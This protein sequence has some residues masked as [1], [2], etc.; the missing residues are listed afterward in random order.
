M[1]ATAAHAATKLPRPPPVPEPLK[2]RIVEATF[3]IGVA[4]VLIVGLVSDPTDLPHEAPVLLAWLLTIVV[5]DLM[6]VPLWGN[7]V[8]SLSL[9]VLLA[10]GMTFSPLIA[11]G[12]AFVGSNDPR[13]FR[14]EVS[15]LHG[16][17]NRSQI[18]ASTLVASIVFHTTGGS[19][20]VWPHVLG[21][22][23][24]AVGADMVVN[25]SLVVL[26]FVLSLSC[27]SFETSMVPSQRAFWSP[28]SRLVWW[29]FSSLLCTRWEARGER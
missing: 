23:L 24:M 20:D 25:Y 5:A 8:L 2:L 15:A 27:K 28:T 10:A 14:R 7:L 4:V 22:S 1:S 16:L 19:L 3:S 13:E 11:G 18:A 9:P 26:A 6:P 29:L 17:Y 12:L 21:I